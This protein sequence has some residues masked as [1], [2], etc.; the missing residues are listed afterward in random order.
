M[1]LSP[2]SPFYGVS[3]RV[4]KAQAYHKVNEVMQDPRHEFTAYLCCRCFFHIMGPAAMRWCL[5]NHEFTDS[6]GVIP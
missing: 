5:S 1:K 6:K 4:C 3:C 2:E